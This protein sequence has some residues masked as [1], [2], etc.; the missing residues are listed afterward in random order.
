MKQKIPERKK[1]TLSTLLYI[2][3]FSLL[4]GGSVSFI[5]SPQFFSIGLI[6]LGVITFVCI[7]IQNKNNSPQK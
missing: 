2:I 4:F 1:N 5:I 7:P 6:V 3:G